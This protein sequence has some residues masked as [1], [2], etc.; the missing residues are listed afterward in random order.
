MPEAAEAAFP[1]AIFQTCVVHLIRSSTRFVPWKDRTAVCADL[2]TIY[3]APSVEAAKDALDAFETKWGKRFPMIATAWRN[4]W[5]EISPFLSFPKEIRHIVYTTNAI[6]G[7]H[8]QMRKVLKTKG[9]LPDDD[10]VLKIIFLVIRN[11]VAWSG[12]ISGWSQASLQ[13]AILFKTR[14]PE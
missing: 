11:A 13:F 12:P 8:R 6:E 14:M 7:L 3:T 9:S 4:P 2:R 1:Q 10:A 5:D